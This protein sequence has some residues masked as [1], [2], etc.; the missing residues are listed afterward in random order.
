MENLRSR[1]CCIDVAITWSM[2]Q[3][4]GFRFSPKTECSRLI[5]RL[6]CSFLIGFCTPIIGPWASLQENNALALAN[7]RMDYN[8]LATNAS[9]VIKYCA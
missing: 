4:K 9:H 6:L 8:L 5:S 1:L 7:Q 2:W 3:G